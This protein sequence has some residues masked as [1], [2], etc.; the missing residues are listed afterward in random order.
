MGLLVECPKC[1]TRNSPKNEQCKCGLHLKKQGHKTYWIEYY[2][3]MGKRKRERIGPS[4][5]AAEQRLREVLKARTEERHIDRD[6]SAKI[7][8]GEL[9]NWYIG[10][11]EVKAKAT[12]KKEFSSIKNLKRL[13]GAET[14]LKDITLGRVEAY[15]KNRLQEPSPRHVGLQ[16]KPATV[17]RELSC[18]QSMFNRAV[19][20]D[21]I[22]KNPISELKRL[23]ENNVRMKILSQNEIENLLANCPSH[24]QPIVILAFY[25][26]MRKSEILY[27]TWEE[28]DLENGFIRLHA[29][30]TKTKIARS[31]PLHP[32]VKT[33]LADLP[34]SQE[35]DRVFLRDGKPFNDFKRAFKTSC[36]KAGL[37]E[38]TFH[39]LRHCAINNLRLAKN[40]YF[41]IM[42]ISGHK[43][44]A[45]FKRYNLVTEDELS[46]VVWG[47]KVDTDG[48]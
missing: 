34:R 25:S 33:L 18:L 29:D 46:S 22:E 32:R 5:S 17:N 7:T 30:R 13:I 45:V 15:Q 21:R 1:K 26:G 12:Y 14:K 39:D 10:L 23:P 9:C 41:K 8:F 27:L 31:I 36:T 28:V 42:A 20:H 44:T 4:K 47:D 43:T 38:F 16:V 24:L 35:T 11:T 37:Q 6:N 3:E 2:D 19:R 40:D 48:R